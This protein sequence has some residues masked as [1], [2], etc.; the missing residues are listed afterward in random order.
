MEYFEKYIKKIH[1]LLSHF[2]VRSVC[3]VGMIGMVG[4]VGIIGIVTYVGTVRNKFNKMLLNNI[5]YYYIKIKFI[6][7][8]YV[9]L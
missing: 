4:M 3:N 2:F 1:Y 9:I 7:N 6:I 8:I 5:Y